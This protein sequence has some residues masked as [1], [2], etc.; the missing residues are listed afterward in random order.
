M[1]LATQYA[2]ALHQL[3]SE[4]PR[5][6]SVY[7]KGLSEALAKRGH[8]KLLPQIMREYEKLAVMGE[9]VERS[10]S[11]TPERERTRVLFELYKK[12]VA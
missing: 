10:R 3:V 12:L 7:I 6:G 2:R 11:V 4:Q 1:T 8:Q 5:S 9:R